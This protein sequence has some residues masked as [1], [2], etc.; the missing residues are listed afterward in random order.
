MEMFKDIGEIEG[1]EFYAGYTISS[2]GYV[3]NRKGK[4]MVNVPNVRDTYFGVNLSTNNISKKVKIHR[5]VA[6]AF[7]SNPEGKQQVNH[8]DCNRQN[9]NVENL[10]WVTNKENVDHAFKMG[11]IVGLAERARIN[12]RKSAEVVSKPVRVFD[13]YGG[14]K[15]FESVKS[16][17]SYLGLSPSY[18]SALVGKKYVYNKVKKYNIEYLERG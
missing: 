3:I 9:N 1:L 17:A 14:Y 15:D 7:I 2:K 8:K 12:G 10:E 6:L 16:A 4:K 5:L 11:R 18:V 13:D